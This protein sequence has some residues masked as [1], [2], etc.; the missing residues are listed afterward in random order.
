MEEIKDIN[1]EEIEKQEQENKQ[2][3]V[4]VDDS[5]IVKQENYDILTMPLLTKTD[6]GIA[7]YQQAENELIRLL[8]EQKKL[9]A[10]ITAIKEKLKYACITNGIKKVETDR[11]S[12]CYVE[13]QVKQ[14][15]NQ[16]RFK[17]ENK[18]LF[19]HYLELKEASDSL[20]LTLREV[21]KGSMWVDDDGVVHNGND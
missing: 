10:K 16:A 8:K 15:F 4:D 20:K 3:V 14:S 13:P 19:E 2:E 9:D 21:K 7:L 1:W 12:V 17:K 5:E 18:D 11:V 6:T